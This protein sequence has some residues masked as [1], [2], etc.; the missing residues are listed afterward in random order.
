MDFLALVAEGMVVVKFRSINMVNA[1]ICFLAA[2]YV[3]NAE[4]P[5]GHTGHS[6]NIYILL[7]HL[8]LGKSSPTY[9]IYVE[10]VL[11]Q[12]WKWGPWRLWTLWYELQYSTVQYNC[13]MG[14]EA[15]YM[16]PVDLDL[17]IAMT[18]ASF[19]INYTWINEFS[20]YVI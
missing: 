12:M 14:V 7:E 20:N 13:N 11:S 9:P 6:K 17:C 15:N 10:N 3:F 5:K 8:L 18:A 19:H 4:Y 2:Y 16:V 1:L